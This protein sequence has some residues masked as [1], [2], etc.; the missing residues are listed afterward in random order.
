MANLAVLRESL[1]LLE[2]DGRV[3]RDPFRASDSFHI[4]IRV[5]PQKPNRRLPRARENRTF[6]PSA[7]ARSDNRCVDVVVGGLP[8]RSRHRAYRPMAPPACN[9]QSRF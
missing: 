6:L 5:K 7:H 9:Q 3:G 4:E 1:D 2:W 8:S